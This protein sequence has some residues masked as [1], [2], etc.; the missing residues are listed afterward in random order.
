MIVKTDKKVFLGRYESKVFGI[1]LEF[2]VENDY[3]KEYKEHVKELSDL[4]DEVG[5]EYKIEHEKSLTID[6]RSRG[7]ENPKD[8]KRRAKELLK[9]KELSGK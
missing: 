5:E 3:K 4:V 6:E 1:E 8:V 9:K 7:M 2:D